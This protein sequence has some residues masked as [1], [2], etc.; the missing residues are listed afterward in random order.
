MESEP[1]D[2]RLMMRCPF[3]GKIDAMCSNTHTPYYQVECQSCGATGPT[4]NVGEAWKLSWTKAQTEA[5]HKRAYRQAI[6]F[7][8]M[9]AGSSG[10]R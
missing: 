9:R 7:W 2:R 6:E 10:D 3:C 4:S 8:N 5:I 1:A